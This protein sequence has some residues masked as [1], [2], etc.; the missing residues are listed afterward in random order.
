MRDIKFR[1]WDA[2][3]SVWICE[4]YHVIGEVTMFG[5]IDQHVQE[6]RH[7]IPSLEYY[8]HILETQFIG[9]TDKNGKEIYEGDV[10]GYNNEMKASWVIEYRANEF[11]GIPL[12]SNMSVYQYELHNRNY[13]QFEVVGNIFE[14]VEL[15]NATTN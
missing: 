5:L 15:A 1:A 11:I 13:L 12:K 14:S 9:L 2:F 6:S 10:V 4:G 3:K 7:G 8:N